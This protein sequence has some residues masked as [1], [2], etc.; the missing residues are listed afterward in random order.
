[1]QHTKTMHGS[2]LYEAFINA[3]GTMERWKTKIAPMLSAAGPGPLYAVSDTVLEE[4]IAIAEASNAIN[5]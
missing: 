4:I 3:G 5:N 1:M 2:E